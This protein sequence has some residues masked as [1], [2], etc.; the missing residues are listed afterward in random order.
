MPVQKIPRNCNFCGH[1]WVGRAKSLCPKCKSISNVEIP[2][3]TI[4]TI[5]IE[6]I[7]VD[8]PPIPENLQQQQQ[9]QQQQKPQETGD[10]LDEQTYIDI[11][12]IPFDVIASI[13]NKD[14]WKLTDREKDTLKKP[15][16]KVADKYLPKWF[17]D[18][19]EEAAFLMAVGLIIMGK[20][21][22]HIADKRKQQEVKKINPNVEVEK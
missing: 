19:P 4:E 5:D 1:N 17:K 21:T 13:T 15:L 22:A 14:Y 11:F 10:F 20:V 2:Q 8:L 18:H 9:P 16:K 3:E 7:K 12:A 6:E